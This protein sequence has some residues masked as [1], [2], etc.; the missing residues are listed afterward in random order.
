MKPAAPSRDHRMP[1]PAA[2]CAPAALSFLLLLL[3]A[4]PAHGQGWI[5]PRPVPRP[6]HWGVEKLRSSV[7]VRVSGSIARVEVEE[8]FRNDGPAA[9]EGDYVYPLHGESVFDS[10]SLYQGEHE[11]RGELMDAAAARRIYEEIVRSRRD[12]ALIELVGRGMLRARV[13]PI[14]PGQS[15]RIALRYTQVLD[16]AGDALQFRYSAGAA[17]PP[18]RSPVRTPGRTPGPAPG[19]ADARAPVALSIIIEDGARF[20]APWSPTHRLEVE[21]RGDRLAITPIA[22]DHGEVAVFLPFAGPAVGLSVATHRPPGEDGWFMLTLSPAAAAASRV[23]RDVTMVVDVSGSMSGEKMEQARRALHQLVGTLD[24]GDRLRLIA[25]SSAVRPWREDWSPAT[26]ARLREARRWADGLRADGGTNIAGALEEALRVA[27]PASR[28]PVIVFLTDGM[29]TVGE[30]NA[31]RITAMV[32][33]GRARA[34]IFVFG[35]GYDVNTHLLDRIGEVARGTTQYVRPEEDVEQAVSVLAA[36]IRHPVL[37]DLTLG[38]ASVELADVY[39]RQLPD[40]FAGQELVL[41]GRYRGSG[42]ATIEVSGRRSGVAERFSTRAAFPARQAGNEY[43]ARLWAAR[44]LGDL[45][46]MV[47]A[48]RADGASQAQ[49]DVLVEELRRTALRHGLLSEY[50]AYLVQEPA[51]AVTARPGALPATAVRLDGAVAV[52]RAEESRRARAV[53]TLAAMDAVQHMAAERLGLEAAGH[54]GDGTRTAGGRHFVLRDGTW[55]DA[56]HGTQRVVAIEPFSDAYF[57]LVRALPE[58]VPVLRELDPVLVAGQH[59][60]IRVAAGGARSL[61]ELAL[62][63]LVQEFRGR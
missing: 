54:R 61:D 32:E 26:P 5:E 31:E 35:V 15:R 30:T 49:V 60:S 58:L 21:R 39:P 41:F 52:Q 51:F 4:L 25:F 33:A 50:T 48:A 9:A 22:A 45:D 29:P 16:R 10:Y 37:T 56:A 13:F 34:R 19:S 8:W 55:H 2:A 59:A 43:I 11:L 57:A 46:R 36:Q 62:R 40:L 53:S 28:L 1:R 20:G 23:P 38:R 14:E 47:R 24:G 6:A 44:K 63:R 42:S 17:R 7:T 18:G 27:S 3:P 12:P